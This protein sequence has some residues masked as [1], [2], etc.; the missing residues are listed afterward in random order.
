MGYHFI[1][2]SVLYFVVGVLLGLYMSMTYNFSFTG[3]HAHVN[4]LGWTS[5]TLAG[6]LYV[7]FPKAGRSILG[8]IHFILHNIGLLIMMVALFTL[9]QTGNEALGPVI[10]I[11]GISLII[12]VILFAI[13]IF[14]NMTPENLQKG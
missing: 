2:I 9:V 6:I 14:R 3:V 8:K 5:M 10:G 12:G 7:L 11:A 1:R 4:L 13:N